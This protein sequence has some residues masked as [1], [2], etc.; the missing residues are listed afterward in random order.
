MPDKIG[1]DTEGANQFLEDGLSLTD[2]TTTVEL[3]DN[4]Q[5]AIIKNNP[6]GNGKIQIFKN[7]EYD[8][9][10]DNGCGIADGS[11]KE[12]L[13]L[14]KRSS[15]NGGNLSKCGMGLNTAIIYKIESDGLCF[16]ITKHDGD[17][18]I[19]LVFYK[20]R[21][22]YYESINGGRVTRNIEDKIPN[23]IDGETG[24]LI[25]RCSN[26]SVNYNE[27]T[28]Q[29]DNLNEIKDYI[30]DCITKLE[31][32]INEKDTSIFNVDDD[33]EKYKDILEGSPCQY[34]LNHQE[35]EK[36]NF[37]NDKDESKL[38]EIIL[39]RQENDKTQNGKPKFFIKGSKI[40]IL[41]RNKH[42]D[43]NSKEEEEVIDDDFIL[44]NNLTKFAK[45]IISFDHEK[46]K[47]YKNGFKI[48]YILDCL[49]TIGFSKF[50]T[51]KEKNKLREATMKYLKMQANIYDSGWLK[52]NALKGQKIN[53][54]YL[55][56][57][58]TEVMKDLQYLFSMIVHDADILSYLDY[59]I[60]VKNKN[61][62]HVK[63]TDMGDSGSD[64]GEEDDDDDGEDDDDDGSDGGGGEVITEVI[65]DDDG[66]EVI[67]EVISDDDDDGGEVI[68]EV[69]SD[70][71]GGEVIIEVIS[72]DDRDDDGNGSPSNNKKKQKKKGSQ[73]GNGGYLYLY[74]LEDSVDWKY[75]TEEQ[76]HR[77][78]M[79]EKD[80]KDES[81]LK[82]HGTEHPA[83]R[84][85]ING[86]WK[87]QAD[88]RRRESEIAKILQ[89]E[90]KQW[91][92]VG[93]TTSDYFSGRTEFLKEIIN[94]SLPPGSEIHENDYP[95]D[96]NTL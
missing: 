51:G 9:I 84:I 79:S 48:Q 53:D 37:L 60:K 91:N 57:E 1:T 52:E 35:I 32:S 93:T 63:K 46:N 47:I 41:M 56:M 50:K 96:L 59:E 6:E 25:Y 82:A 64:D 61:N 83:N 10:I 3:L 13:K 67:T 34:Y 95:R 42:T 39:Y 65:S 26:F 20:G 77:W 69:I 27:E 38:K 5:K 73:I 74:T 2:F 22:L 21:Y 49:R 29:I 14:F 18:Y 81:R 76:I 28:K 33:L 92:A 55:E 45:I 16:I 19:H 78:G 72:D 40:S 17:T 12:C 80:D 89:E 68:T 86:I 66:G 24:T 31:N 11:I 54:E 85:K 15:D 7:T 62:H 88:V 75:G 90:G 71:D 4:C 8:Y 23:I 87:I 36:N 30:I 94:S 43:M 44:K 70:D 58:M